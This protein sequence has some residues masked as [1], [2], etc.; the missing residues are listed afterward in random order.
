MWQLF[1]HV[2][3]KQLPRYATVNGF[4][5][6][7][8]LNLPELNVIEEH[9]V[10]VRLPFQQIRE[11]T[12]FAGVKKFVGQVINVSVKP[13]SLLKV[14]QRKLSDDLVLNTC[15]KK[16]VLRTLCAKDMKTKW[17]REATA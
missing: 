9:L 17:I 6:P 16:M 12:W 1:N 13:A 10:A 8:L 2:S 14:L 4:F 11:I 15:G 3:R 7:H 5:Y